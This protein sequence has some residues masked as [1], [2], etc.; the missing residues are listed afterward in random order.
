MD[1]KSSS[2]AEQWVEK[3]LQSRVVF[4]MQST[5]YRL[6]LRSEKDFF[7]LSSKVFTPTLQW[8]VGKNLQSHYSVACIVP[9]AVVQKATE[10]N[11]IKRRV[12][13][14]L[15][16]NKEALPTRSLVVMVRRKEITD[17]TL[18]ES[19]STL[20]HHTSTALSKR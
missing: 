6:H 16:N 5:R 11:R 4:P 13:Q 18:Y 8:F 7:Q 2:V 12:Y 20:R 1:E 15:F 9:K 19:V 14:Y 10:R 17:N 3:N